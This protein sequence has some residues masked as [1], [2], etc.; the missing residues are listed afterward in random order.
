MRIGIDE[1]KEI[2]QFSTTTQAR[3]GGYRVDRIIDVDETD[4]KIKHDWS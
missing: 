2:K 3:R 4:G 1:V